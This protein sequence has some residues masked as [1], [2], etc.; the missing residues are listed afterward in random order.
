MGDN[1][2]EPPRSLWFWLIDGTLTRP[3]LITVNSLGLGTITMGQSPSLK[4]IP[5]NSATVSVQSTNHLWGFWDS[6]IFFQVARHQRRG[7]VDQRRPEE[8]TCIDWA[9]RKPNNL[10][11]YLRIERPESVDVDSREGFIWFLGKFV[12]QNKK[13]KF[14]KPKNLGIRISQKNTR[15]SPRIMTDQT[16]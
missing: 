8:F 16:S 6:L 3:Y 7:L 9:S 10:W 11:N 5:Y 4:N 13:S 15:F 1:E 12:P 14:L 2:R